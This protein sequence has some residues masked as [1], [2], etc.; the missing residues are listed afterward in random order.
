MSEEKFTHD[1][2]TV[3]KFIQLY[4]DDKH[5]HQEEE[6][7]EITY[8]NK[9]LFDTSFHL[10]PTCKETFL[11]SL[12]RL[13]NCPHEPKPKCGKCETSCY[14]KSMRE[15]IAKIMRYSGMKLGMLK[16]KNLFTRNT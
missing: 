8:K 1:I 3:L 5:T 14:K 7:I 6:S 12:K 11:Y 16:I 10:C 2:Q 13:Q 4:C 9:K 15:E